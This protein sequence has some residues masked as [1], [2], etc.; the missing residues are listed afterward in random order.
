MKPKAMIFDMDGVIFDSETLVKICWKM[1]ADKYGIPGIEEQCNRC[2]GTNMEESRRIMKE[3]YGQDFPYDEYKKEMSDLFHERADGGKLPQKPG[4]RELL[5]YLKEQGIRTAVASSTRSN[6]VIQELDEGGLLGFFDKVI[7]GEMVTR[8]K[9]APDIFLHA[10][11][12][13]EVSPKEA[14]VVEDSFN[15]IRAAS[16]AGIP[17]IMVPDQV[18]PDEEI[19]EK[20]EIVLPSLNAVKEYIETCN[21][22]CTE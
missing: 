8:S 4:V 12:Q 17:A 19:R 6:L 5:Q 15:G 1:V 13:L 16:A 20:A 18:Q 3:H 10:C 21:L 14:Y 2:L 9:P 11:E 22:G 7:G